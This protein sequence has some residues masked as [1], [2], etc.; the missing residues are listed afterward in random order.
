V[1][2]S[3]PEPRARFAGRRVLVTGATGFLGSHVCAALLAE[4]AEVHALARSTER[5]PRGTRAHAADLTRRDAARD[6]LRS[7][8]PA[9]V[10]HAAGLVTASPSIE[11]VR[12]ALAHDCVA[13]VELFLAALEAG[14][15]RIV[16][17][18]SCEE[19]T[20]PRG[21]LAPASPYAAAKLSARA[22]AEMLRR[23]H[24]APISCV[25]PFTIY[26]PG[27]APEKL[28]PSIALALAR[29]ERPRL[30]SAARVLDLVHV[31]D[32]AA[33]VLAALA[34]P[35]L[36]EPVELGTGRGVAVAE[37]ARELARAAGRPELE[38]L[39]EA[40][41][42]PRE[43]SAVLADCGPA[44]RLLEWEPLWSLGEG[45]RATYEWY[46]QRAGALR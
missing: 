46:R 8:R 25:L 38:P 19:L 36:P 30:R 35:V 1:R 42:R 40:P 26:G 39:T 20:E 11:L 22:H 21:W 6:A 24:D 15:A 28:V 14:C 23:A 3:P 10:V 2:S 27:Q 29:G 45:L 37:L 33:G 18:G 7:I 32:V 31:E 5:A 4:G 9:L 44:R 17:V 13:A 12:E 34:A 16:H 43:A 41:D